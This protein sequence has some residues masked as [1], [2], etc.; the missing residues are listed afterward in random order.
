MELSKDFSNPRRQIRQIFDI[1]TH[2]Q[3][4]LAK[5]TFDTNSRQEE[6]KHE[7]D[8]ELWLDREE[9]QLTAK[10]P[11]TWLLLGDRINKVFHSA[12]KVRNSKNRINQLIDANGTLISEMS[13]LRT[14]APRFYEELF[15]QRDYWNIFP[16]LVKRVLTAEA[17][18]VIG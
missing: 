14:H 5:A 13:S 12:T 4:E 6:A 18:D 17:C 10:S 11:E 8:L 2:I 7:L 15:N 16:D 1:L 9:D 3:A